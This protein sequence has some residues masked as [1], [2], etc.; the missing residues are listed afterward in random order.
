MY[1]Y[2]DSETPLASCYLNYQFCWKI[3]EAITWKRDHIE[4]YF[5]M[6]FLSYFCV[7]NPPLQYFPLFRTHPIYIYVYIYI[8]IYIYIH[9]Y[10]YMYIYFWTKLSH[11]FFTF[12]LKFKYQ[13]LKKKW[14]KLCVNFVQQYIHICIYNVYLCI[15]MYIYVYI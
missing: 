5:Y 15:Y 1:M 6:N 12:S 11:N 2:C 14:K 13:F 7:M 9:I 8:Y 10:I 4:T 3:K